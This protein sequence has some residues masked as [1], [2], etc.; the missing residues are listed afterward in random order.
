VRSIA[1][2]D[3]DSRPTTSPILDLGIKHF[4]ISFQDGFTIAVP[5]LGAPEMPAER[6]MDG[7]IASQCRS[8]PDDKWVQTSPAGGNTFEGCYL[9]AIGLRSFYI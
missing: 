2:I 4:T 1:V 7:P 5:S 6:L 3:Q 9:S 8:R